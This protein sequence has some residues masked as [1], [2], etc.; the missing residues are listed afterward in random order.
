MELI[1]T[2]VEFVLH[3]DRHLDGLIQHFGPWIYVI[4]FLVI[5]C[6]TGLV[7]TPF[8]EP[9]THGSHPRFL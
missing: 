9:P 3:V 4:L 6:E 5:F 1:K 8:S 2:L 7:V